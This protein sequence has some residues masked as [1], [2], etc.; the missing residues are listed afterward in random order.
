MRCGGEGMDSLNNCIWW[1]CLSATEA[2]ID[3]HSYLLGASGTKTMQQASQPHQQDFA[4]SVKTRSRE[5]LEIP[6]INF[7]L[8]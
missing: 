7:L 6:V 8:F 5:I 1:F 2:E 3:A 4:I